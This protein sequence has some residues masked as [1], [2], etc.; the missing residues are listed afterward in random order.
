M[1]STNKRLAQKSIAVVVIITLLYGVGV[2]PL[3]MMFIT[4]L[5]L[6]VFMV[7]RR[8]QSKEVE[9]IFDF[10]LAAE[11][12]LRDEDRRWYG[13]EVTEVIENGEMALEEI[14]DPP[15]LLLF[16]LGALHH[17]IGN[18]A[19]TREYLSRIVEDE[20]YDE[21]HRTA[22]SG[23]LRRYVT[24]LRRIEAEPSLA[25]QTLGAIRSLERMRR[26]RAFNM[27]AET[28]KA[29][30]IVDPPK[31]NQADAAPAQSP[32][33]NAATTQRLSPPPPITE[34][35][36]DIYQDEHAPSN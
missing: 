4:G 28:R 23:Q 22:P 17:L 13:F 32:G 8:A 5:V 7:S 18:N 29:L 19:S 33:A 27:L 6:V 34:V 16:T 36:N 30:Q 11:A 21:R 1:K 3:V 2:A 12:I 9:R 14:P 25:P 26:R 24:L 20:Y 15:P 10:Y 31:M 35:L